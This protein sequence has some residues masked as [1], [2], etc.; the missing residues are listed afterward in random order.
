MTSN[1]AKPPI[2][3]T[4]VDTARVVVLAL[5]TGWARIPPLDTA[6]LLSPGTVPMT[7][8]KPGALGRCTPASGA[9]DAAL[10]GRAARQWG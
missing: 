10:P 8:G 4:G 5:A 1:R 7:I 9:A 2:P 3:F 6:T